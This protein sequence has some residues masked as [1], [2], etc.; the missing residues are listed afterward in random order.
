MSKD[1]AGA[2]GELTSML[3]SGTF[4][5]ILAEHKSS[6]Q[7]EV[8]AFVKKQDLPNAYAALRTMEDVDRI[9]RLMQT[10]LDELKK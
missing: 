3:M 8:N 5:N 9:V 6:L 10:R 7:K 4:H 1:K 2:I